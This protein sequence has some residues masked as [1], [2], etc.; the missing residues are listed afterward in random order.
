VDCD[1]LGGAD[2]LFLGKGMPAA[3]WWITAALGCHSHGRIRAT[4]VQSTRACMHACGGVL[5]V[6]A[7]S[8]VEC[9]AEH[10]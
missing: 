4:V 9:D 2:S 6:R 10:F 1:R 7:A 5:R 8:F 3:A